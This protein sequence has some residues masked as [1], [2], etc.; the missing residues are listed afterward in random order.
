MWLAWSGRAAHPLS[1]SFR[2][3]LFSFSGEPRGHPLENRPN[4][5]YRV[6]RCGLPRLQ[7]G[8]AVPGSCADGLCCQRFARSPRAQHVMATR[9]NVVPVSSA[10]GMRTEA[11][12]LS[13]DMCT[14]E[15]GPVQCEQSAAHLR[16]MRT[17]LI[18][19]AGRL[20]RVQMMILRAV[21]AIWRPYPSGGWSGGPGQR[22]GQPLSRLPSPSRAPEGSQFARQSPENVRLNC[23]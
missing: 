14:F 3:S 18:W 8:W 9:F 10:H 12:G 7:H 6:R 22:I 5:W 13:L 1:L 15:H 21:R 23:A 11:G 16:A 2:Q 19:L 4:A 20:G 17:L